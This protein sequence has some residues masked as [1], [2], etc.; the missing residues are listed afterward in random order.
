MSIMCGWG[1]LKF[2]GPEFVCKRRGKHVALK[3]WLRPGLDCVGNKTFIF[4]KSFFIFKIF[5]KV[6]FSLF[7]QGKKKSYKKKEKNNHFL[8]SF[9]KLSF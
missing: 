5:L 1:L 6:Y 9:T 2:N 8:S 4:W 3:L 7:I